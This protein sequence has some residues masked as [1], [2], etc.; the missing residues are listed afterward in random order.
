M[1]VLLRTVAWIACFVYST[2]P[3]FWLLIHSRAQFWRSRRQ[4]PY[5]IVLPVW[6]GMWTLVA[7]ITAPWRDLSL[8]ESHWT[9]I[10]AGVLF[11][12]GLVLYK[13]A[14][15]N[16]TLTQ[17]GGLPEIRPDHGQ[18][19]LVKTGI[20]ARVRHPVYLGHLCEMLAWSLSTGLAV[21]W[22]L[23]ALAVASGAVMIKLEDIELENRFGE[24][25]RQYRSAVPAVLPRRSPRPV[26]RKS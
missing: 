20:R 21:C 5:W 17:L 14:H 7:A 22:A 13:L 19:R 3:A 25:Y 1:L 9:W 12:A 23:T 10:P 26:H 11:G 8:F 15:V 4:S 16:F 6:I 24:E 18:Q 2:I